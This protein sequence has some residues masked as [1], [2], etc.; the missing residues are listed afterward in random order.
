MAT[1]TIG[2]SSELLSV[3]PAG[4]AL[5]RRCWEERA[6]WRLE[7]SHG[8]C[9]PF[10]P[11]SGHGFEC[12][13]TPRDCSFIL[14]DTRFLLFG[15][16]SGGFGGLNVKSGKQKQCDAQSGHVGGLDA[17]FAVRKGGG[18]VRNWLFA[19]AEVRSR[20]PRAK[21]HLDD[22]QMPVLVHYL[23]MVKR[24]LQV[25]PIDMATC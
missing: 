7:S 18:G 8:G 15:T 6:M 1:G 16:S 25:T 5:R 13:K 3:S 14:C 23:T 21:D 20:R 9:R 10:S 22:D 2:Q 12:A 4:E 17:V 24:E 11:N 19:V